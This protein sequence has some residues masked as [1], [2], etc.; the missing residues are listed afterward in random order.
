MSRDGLKGPLIIKLVCGH[1]SD[2]TS[3]IHMK[4]YNALNGYLILCAHPAFSNDSRISEQE[5]Q[6][7]PMESN[8]ASSR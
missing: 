8:R 4:S 1:N 3:Q 6:R 2:T 5:S 7:I